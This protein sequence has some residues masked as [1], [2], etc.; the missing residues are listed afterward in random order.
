[1]C[2]TVHHAIRWARATSST[3]RPEV[4]TASSTAWRSRLKQR[5]RNG[6]W[7]LTWVK[8]RRSQDVSRHTSLALRT[9]T[10]TGRPPAGTSFTRCS[11]H[12][13]TR[14][15]LVPQLGQSPPTTS[16]R[17]LTRRPPLGR[18]TASNTWYP[19]RLKMT[20]AAS[21]CE[22]VRSFTARGPL[23]DGCQTHPSQQGHEPLTSLP[24]HAQL[25]RA[26]YRGKNHATHP[27]LGFQRSSQ[28]LTSRSCDV[29]TESSSPA[30]ARRA[31]DSRT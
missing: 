12:E 29:S 3:A 7:S 1:M 19:G 23:L 26:K 9:A 10:C 28:H 2:C 16:A 14:M 15:E 6:S 13:C 27:G 21:R 20:P 31:V 25:R 17:T 8:V 30:W 22:H 11:V 4:M 18:S 24:D 5:A